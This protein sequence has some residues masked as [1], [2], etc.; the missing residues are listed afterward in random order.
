M[1]MAGYSLFDLSGKRGYVTGG[2]SGLGRAIALGLAEAGAAVVVSDI[3][4]T[5]A[6]GVAE[7]I[8]AQGG[9]ALA[10]RTDVTHQVEVSELVR[11]T[12]ERF[13]GLDFAFNNAGMLKVIK[14][15]DLSEQ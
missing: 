12:S 15:E 10:L 6:E 13:G 5:A 7:E 14:P 3:N 8:R 11:V 2:G 4:Q 9:Q 1:T